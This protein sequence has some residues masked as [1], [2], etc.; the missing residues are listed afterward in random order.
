MIKNRIPQS[1]VE[2]LGSY[3]STSKDHCQDSQ[4]RTFEASKGVVDQ[5]TSMVDRRKN[6]V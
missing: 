6:V 4:I 5:T 1:W 3:Q 2:A